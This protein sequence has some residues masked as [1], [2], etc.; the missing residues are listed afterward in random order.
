MNFFSV[1]IKTP[2]KTANAFNDMIV[3]Q[4]EYLNKG[5]NKG[6]VE[7]ITK[8]FVE[9]Q[10]VLLCYLDAAIAWDEADNVWEAGHLVDLVRSTGWSVVCW[11]F[12]D[13][14]PIFYQQKD[15]RFVIITDL[16]HPSV[17]T[18]SGLQVEAG[19]D[20]STWYCVFYLNFTKSVCSC[21]LLAIPKSTLTRTAQNS[22]DIENGFISNF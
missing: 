2:N 7:R 19:Y 11:G 15:G 6:R 18:F 1:L 5:I 10:Q 16:S 3:K 21:V 14:V 12:E 8:D 22:L 9:S 20:A 17:V 4:A 13:C